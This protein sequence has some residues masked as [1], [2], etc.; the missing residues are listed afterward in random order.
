[1][2]RP[3]SP[4]AARN[5][6][7]QQKLLSL[8]DTDAGNAEAF[9][10][11][12][13][14]RFR[15]DRSRGKWLTWNG[16]FWEADDRGAVERA[17]LA[18]VRA[19]RAAAALIDNHKEANERLRW[20][21]RSESVS[22]RESMLRSAQSIEP[23]ATTSN[24]YDV[25]I[26]LL[27]VGNGTL[28]LESG[29]IHEAQPRDL[30]T[31]ATD[32]KYVA[33]ASCPRWR[34]FL[35]EVFAGDDEL[36]DFIQRAVGYS[37]TGD[38]R[39]QC[40]FILFGQGAN[41]KTTF[42]ETVLK[43][44]GTHAITTAFSAFLAQR[45]PGSPRNDLATLRGARFVKAAEA[46]HRAHL[47]EAIVKQLTGGDT[48]SAR[49]LYHE[50]F[51]FRP[52][53]KIWL[54]TNHKP[55]IRGTDNAIWRRIR[56]IPFTQQFDDRA[57]RTLLEKLQAEL[58]GILAWAVAG[59]RSWLLHGL[60]NSRTVETATHAYKQ[61]SDQFGRFLEE[62]CTRGKRF[63]T[64]GK[65]LYESYAKWCLSSGEKPV[66]NSIFAAALVERG[67]S[68][69]RGRKGVVYEGLGLLPVTSPGSAIP[70]PSK[71]KGK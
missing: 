10:L 51:S 13:G 50:Q 59:C 1:M 39:E 46:E 14:D 67:I 63:C 68:K 26:F 58:D 30:I 47:D 24:E 8:P 32:A 62:R 55:D 22:S 66:S 71:E 6:A 54:A 65:N 27:T 40:L 42:L 41:G 21:L 11:L 31:K 17:A 53:F 19:R 3:E 18:T 45:S 52:Q 9:G 49:F 2:H 35:R 48:I 36:I 4:E 60:G 43:L 34:S 5:K 38:A 44:L 61:E 64:T 56:L 16:R 33:S 29:E 7:L 57:D 20:A 12:Y 69:K 28:N 23:F 15:Y 70:P 37:L 25:D